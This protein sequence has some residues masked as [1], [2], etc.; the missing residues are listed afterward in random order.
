MGKCET[1]TNELFVHLVGE[2]GEE[3]VTLNVLY[4]DFS[5]QGECITFVVL[6]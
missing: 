3:E 6:S 1:R 5:L 4:T 2:I